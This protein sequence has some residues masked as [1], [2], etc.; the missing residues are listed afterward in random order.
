MSEMNEY[1]DERLRITDYVELEA[2]E[3]VIEM[4]LA[5]TI[6]FDGSE[7]RVWKVKTAEHYYWVPN[8]GPLN[9]YVSGDDNPTFSDADQAFS[10][11]IG[12]TERLRERQHDSVLADRD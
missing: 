9:L 1:H 8:Y 5:K 11:H 6:T 2:N 12:V 3:K 4:E 7:H 10:F